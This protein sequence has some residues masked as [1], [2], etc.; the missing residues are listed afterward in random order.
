LTPS[1]AV[2][3]PLIL[4]LAASSGSAPVTAG[5]L[6]TVARTFADSENGATTSRSAW[7]RPRSGA[8]GA[9][10]AFPALAVA[11]VL[12][13][14]TGVPLLSALPPSNGTTAWD[15]RAGAGR[16]VG[17]LA[18]ANF[19]P[20]VVL[21]AVVF[22]AVVFP[23]VV[24]PAVVLPAVVFPA[25]VLP[26]VVFPA[27]V[28]PAVVFPAVVLPAVVLPADMFPADALPTGVL[29]ADVPHAETSTV[30][31]A[32]PITASTLVTAD[33]GRRTPGDRRGPPRMIRREGRR[34]VSASKCISPN[35]RALC[36]NRSERR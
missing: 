3:V 20:A 22:P 18:C 14:G 33:F 4:I 29:A 7:R 35:I 13:T 2:K 15:R 8:T 17:R 31:T 12:A 19:F 25:V 11:T 32:T 36:L 34:P 6:D 21:P 27:V 9:D 26:A 5:C 1:T 16:A 10:R 28:F 30:P 23:A 24:L